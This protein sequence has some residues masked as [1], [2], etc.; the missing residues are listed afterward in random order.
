MSTE[1]TEI[2]TIGHSTHSWEHFIALLRV[3]NVTAVA[4]VRS[5][6]YSRLFR[7]FNRDELREELRLDGISYV[8]L[9]K[10]LGG[11]PSEHRFYRDGVA[12]YEKMSQAPK[13]SEG[14]DRVIE[15]AKKY[16]I[17]LMCSERDPLD[18]HRCLLVGRALAER[19][20]RV[21]HILGD[22]GIASH[23][24]IED[25]LLKLSGR[26]NEDFFAPRSERLATA[27][28]ERARKVAFAESQP[29]PRGPV[30]AE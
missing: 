24:E 25:K 8:F 26:S 1:N 23:S 28:R 7:H 9:G 27:Y 19:G 20:I 13:F 11:R 21:T 22:G 12:D 5:S 14:L 15:G 30:A 6:P 18:C 10:E 16:R 17:A 4:D 2:L 3:A 29:D